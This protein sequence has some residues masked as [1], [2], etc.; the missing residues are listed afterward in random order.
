MIQQLKD[1]FKKSYIQYLIICCAFIISIV[2]LYRNFT[3]S[4]FNIYRH[5]IFDYHSFFFHSH[6]L[7]I[8]DLLG[9]NFS[10]NFPFYLIFGVLSILLFGLIASRLFGKRLAPLSVLFFAISGW[11]GYL[12][13]FESFYI[14]LMFLILVFCWGYILLLGKHT[15]LGRLLIISS[16]ALLILSALST[17]IMTIFVLTILI[18]FKF[19][20]K[21]SLSY[22]LSTIIII[23]LFLGAV[24]FSKTS[25]VKNIYST[26]I[27]FL[28]DPGI[29]NESNRLQGNTK[30]E[31][32]PLLARLVENKYLYTTKYIALKTASHLNPS[33]YFTQ[34]EKLANF[35]FTPP[36]FL[37]LIIPFAY[38]LYGLT[39]Q[40]KNRKYLLLG[41]CLTIP[42]ILSQKMI[43]LN[44]LVLI[45]PLIF[46]IVGFGIK[47]LIQNRNR[48]SRILFVSTIILVVLQF[49][50]VA[51]D[52]NRRE[53]TRYNV[54][55]GENPS[56]EVGKQ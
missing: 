33:A 31:G 1:A 22:L 49:A 21:R 52:I 56:F 40:P 23:F 53:E 11:L 14:Y 2:Y 20:D 42:S 10:F 19:L 47:Q 9:I 18:L 15:K 8:L 34:E 16:T 41:F 36:I 54:V 26:Q 50:F 39:K 28:S 38:G 12:I 6:N 5:T 17:A 45:A 3:L 4:Y 30:Q 25:A 48:L 24:M 51:N 55:F 44:R 46:L 29:L 43:D 7:F 35:S 27:T 37:G 13:V 32:F